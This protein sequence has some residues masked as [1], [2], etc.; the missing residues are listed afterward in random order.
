MSSETRAYELKERA[1]RQEETRQR[2]AAA[3][4]ELH[5]E[6]GPAKTTIAEIARRAGVQRPTVYNN[7]PAERELYAAC[8][9]HFFGQHPLPDPSA[10]LALADPAARARAVLTLFYGWYRET[11]AMTGKIQRDRRLLPELDAL[12]AEGADPLLDGIA[13]Q[14]AAAFRLRGKRSARARAALRLALDFATWERL[15]LEGLADAEA[16]AL[17]VGAATARLAPLP[18][19]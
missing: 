7:F 15:S 16:A 9:A 1:R 5:E 8:Q 2:I 19:G 11:A 18:A 12:L 13:A 17:M 10:A 14:L 4:A 6:D 3:T